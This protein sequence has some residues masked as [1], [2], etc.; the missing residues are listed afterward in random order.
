[1]TSKLNETVPFEGLIN[2][3]INHKC[4]KLRFAECEVLYYHIPCYP[5]ERGGAKRRRTSCVKITAN[6]KNFPTEN[7]KSV[8]PVKKTFLHL[9]TIPWHFGEI[10]SFETTDIQKF[11]PS[12]LTG[13]RVGSWPALAKIYYIHYRAIFA[14]NLPLASV[15]IPLLSDND[16]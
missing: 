13:Q 1:M 4:Q 15:Y 10:I 16:R 12:L 6:R 3:K 14:R 9:W 11:S 2:F 5:C 7:L 8:L